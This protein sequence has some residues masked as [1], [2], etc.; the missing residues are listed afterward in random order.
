VGGSQQP[1][2]FLV[3]VSRDGNPYLNVSGL[4]SA[5]E[6]VYK[7]MVFRAYYHFLVLASFGGVFSEPV[8]SDYFISG[9]T[10]MF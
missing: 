2:R 5:M 4:I 6:Y 3:Q 8:E 9:V 7:E 1:V 10:G